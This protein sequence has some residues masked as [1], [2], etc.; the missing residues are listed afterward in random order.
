[1]ISIAKDCLKDIPQ[2]ATDTDALKR[3]IKREPL[4]VIAIVAPWK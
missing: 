2:T 3:Y 4:G 1:L